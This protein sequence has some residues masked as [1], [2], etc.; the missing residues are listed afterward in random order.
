MGTSKERTCF[1][2]TTVI[3]INEIPVG[4]HSNSFMFADD[5]KLFRK[6]HTP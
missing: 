4:L 1:G 2:P 6:N 3:Y 5:T